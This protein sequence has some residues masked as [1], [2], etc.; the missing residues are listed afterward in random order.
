MQETVIVAGARTAFGKLGGMWSGLTAVELGGAAIR[1]AVERAGSEI[2]AAEPLPIDAVLMGMALQAGAG[3]NPARQAARQA[4]LPWSVTVETINKVCASGLRAITLADQLIRAGG[5]ATVVAGGMESMSRAPHA[6]PAARWGQRMGDAALVDLMLRDG[7]LCAYDG[8]HMA[9]HGSRVAAE[10]AIGREEQDDWALRSHERAL[11]AIRHGRFADEIIPV[12]SA[13]PETDEGPRSDTDAG[14]LARLKP[15]YSPAGTITAGNAPGV[16]DGAAAVVAMA[17]DKAMELG[18]PAQASIIG[19][20]TVGAE[21]PYI[22]TVPALAIRKLMQQT[23]YSLQ[24]VDLFEVNEAFAAVV[25]TCGKLLGWDAEKVNVNGG[26]I[27]LGHPIGASGARIVLTLI[28]SLK[29]RGGGLG[30]AAIC[31]GGGQGDAVLI[32]VDG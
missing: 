14:K 12:L 8:L 30:I 1:G 6:L 7:L 18:L 19:H 17:R 15:I 26:A 22:A 21:A 32:R 4:G 28:H 27:A 3:Q 11:A 5:A 16:N 23:G 31:S 25:L 29:R 20:A 24:D 10:Y 2:G 13:Q 9:V